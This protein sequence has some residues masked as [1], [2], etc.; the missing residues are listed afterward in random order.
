[1]NVIYLFHE[2]GKVII[3]F[4]GFDQELY[5]IFRTHFYGHWIWETGCF[6]IPD[7]EADSQRGPYTICGAGIDS[8]TGSVFHSVL[9]DR[10]WVWAE[11]DGPSDGSEDPGLQP[12]LP[13]LSINGFFYRDWGADVQRGNLRAS[14][15]IGIPAKSAARLT[16]DRSED[17]HSIEDRLIEDRLIE[18]RLMDDCLTDDRSIKDE[19]C[20]TGSI[21]PPEFFTSVWAYQLETELR[22]RK[23]SLKTIKSYIHYNKDFC[24]TMR[25][26][27]PDITDIDVK[28]Y[29]ACLDRTRDL[30]TSSMNLAISSIKF[31][32]NVVLKK[33]FA[34]NQY[35]PRHDKRLPSVLDKTEVQRLLNFEKNP[36]HR[37]L[38]MLVYA[39]G[40][41]VSEVVALKREHI[42]LKRKTVLVHSGKGRKDR[43]T[44]LSDRAAQF[45]SHYYTIY[46]PEEWLFP[47]QTARHHLSIRS[48]QSIFDKAIRKAEISKQVSIHSLRHTFATHLLESGTDVRYI[49]NLLGHASI[50]TTERYTHVA[51]RSV[52]KIQSPLDSFDE[53]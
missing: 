12:E 19:E 27:P 8:G 49:Q 23:Y 43:Y 24:R 13:R 36:K 45:I 39:S 44:M 6:E 2:N 16:G 22:S 21:K 30:S 38:L 26:S 42:D 20:L 10:I 31:F 34:R 28:R 32:Y 40:L 48:A 4:Y 11:L 9:A 14:P 53:S 41:R 47:G 51:R 5:S 15:E 37:L 46:E 52:L 33:D 17:G 25:K 3:P 1:M 29:L 50:R 18:D 7:G 35:R